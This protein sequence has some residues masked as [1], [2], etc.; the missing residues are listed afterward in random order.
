MLWR[1]PR[2]QFEAQKGEG[3]RRAMQALVASGARP[4][5]LAYRGQRPVGWCAVA[6]RTDYPALARSRILK[7]VDAAPCWSIACL[8]IHK[9]HRRQGVS[10]RLLEAAAA[11]ARTNGAVILEGYPVEPPPGKA[12]PAAFAWTGLASAFRTAGF[13]EAARRAPTRPIMRRSLRPSPPT[14]A[15]RGKGAPP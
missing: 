3:N 1:L 11:F 5:L 15:G 9:A 2:R 6:P 14:A 10:I 7:P 8:F 12:L 4:G 13:V